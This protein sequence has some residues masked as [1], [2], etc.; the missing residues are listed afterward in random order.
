[1]P[2]L[3]QVG[4]DMSRRVAVFFTHYYFDKS[5]YNENTESSWA[6]TYFSSLSLIPLLVKNP[7]G[8]PDV[9]FQKNDVYGFFSVFS[10]DGRQEEDAD[11]E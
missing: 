10:A 2:K 4:M 8:Q 9:S 11:H 7:S 5:R 1:M 6:K 3:A